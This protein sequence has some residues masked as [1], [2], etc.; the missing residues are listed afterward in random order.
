MKWAKLVDDPECFIQ[1]ETP[2]ERLCY[3]YV[4]QR[5]LEKNFGVWAHYKFPPNFKVTARSKKDYELLVGGFLLFYDDIVRSG[6]VDHAVFLKWETRDKLASDDGRQALVYDSVT[7]FLS[8][9]P[10]TRDSHK[11][12]SAQVI[13]QAPGAREQYQESMPAQ[14]PSDSFS[15]D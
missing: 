14:A 12:P 1:K 9:R 10:M 13:S 7:I 5:D 2:V 15:V 8:P 3:K 11:H 6:V 4:N